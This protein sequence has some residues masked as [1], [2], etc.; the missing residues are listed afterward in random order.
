MKIGLDLSVTSSAMVI[1]EKFFNYTTESSTNKWIKLTSE[2]INFRFFDNIKQ[3]TYSENEIYKLKKY[4]EIT[5]LIFNDIVS[6]SKNKELDVFIEGYSY[7][8]P[9][10]I[11]DLA[12]H[13]TLLKSKLLTLD[14]LKSIKII[15]PMSLKKSACVQVYGYINKIGKKGQ[16]LKGK[17]TKNNEGISGGRFTKHEMFRAFVESDIKNDFIQHC[18]EI[19]NSVLKMKNI[20]KPY[21]DVIDSWFLSRYSDVV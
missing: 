6:F 15:P 16:I 9:G 10:K 18:Y 14:N 4:D 17:Q 5:N 7:G 20:P 19:K 8:S 3:D 1:D 12:A 11:P 2:F 13:S 21:D